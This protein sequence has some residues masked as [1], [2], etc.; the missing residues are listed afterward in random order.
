MS[1][2][3]NG[4]RLVENDVGGH[5][6]RVA[7]QPVVDVVGLFPDLILE[8]GHPRQPR[9]GSDHAEQRV[10]LRHLGDVRLDEE[11]ALLR[12][13]AGREPVQHHLMGILPEQVGILQRRQGMDVHDAVDAVVVAL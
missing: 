1:A 10:E 2:V 13:E 6:H 9:E 4:V 5:Q 8:R 12:I 7:H 3:M 11:D